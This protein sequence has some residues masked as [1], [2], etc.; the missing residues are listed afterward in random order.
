MVLMMIMVQ[1]MKIMMLIFIKND[2]LFIDKTTGA[3]PGG[4]A[5]GF[6]KVWGAVGSGF[7]ADVYLIL[8]C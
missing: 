7:L 3:R 6:L 2:M 4:L 1:Q 5:L 8:R